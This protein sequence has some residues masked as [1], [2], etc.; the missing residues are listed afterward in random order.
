M[1][2]NPPDRSELAGIIAER[3]DAEGA[4]LRAAWV[5]SQ[6][7]RHFVVSD[8]FPEN[9]AREIHAA[10]PGA[11]AL[12]ERRSLREHKRV[13]VDLE[14]YDPLIANV[15]LAFQ[16]STVIAAVDRIV[17][18]NSLEPDPSLYAAGISLMQQGDFLNPH[19]DNSHDGD[20]RLYRALNLLYYATPDWLPEDGGQLELW[21]PRIERP[22]TVG[23]AF[24]QLVVMS[25]DRNSWHSVSRVRS[26]RTRCC[27]SNYFFSEAPLGGE[28]YSHVTTFAGRPDEPLKRVLLRLDGLVLNALGRALP[29]LTRRSWHRRSGPPP[30]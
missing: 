20:H 8:L 14:A 7:T 11:E 17:G 25:T 27:V 12:A 19:L 15:Q 6:P 21:T 3:I 23:A 5:E 28:A 26:N 1:A 30:D 10:M 18:S 4:R 24:N 29:F 22:I 16:Q 9:L 13:G 2:S